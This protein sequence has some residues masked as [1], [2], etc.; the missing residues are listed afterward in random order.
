MS[1]ALASKP[2]SPRKCPFLGSR[3]V[4]FYDLLKMGQGHDF[5]FLRLGARQRPRGNFFWR[6]FQILRNICEILGR[7]PFLFLETTCKITALALGLENSCSQSREG[8]SS[9]SWSLATDFFVSLASSLVSL[10]PP[11]IINFKTT[12]SQLQIA[13]QQKIVILQKLKKA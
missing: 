2:A 1:L 5:F 7:R 4:I 13:Q 12:N 6:T 9:G 11:P 8:L 10:T 3:K